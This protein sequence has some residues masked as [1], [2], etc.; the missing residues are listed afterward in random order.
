MSTKMKIPAILCITF[1]TVL[2]LSTCATPPTGPKYVFLF[3]G[4][5]MGSN[6]VHAAEMYA[7]VL[8]SNSISSIKTAF[9]KFPVTGLMTNHSDGNFIT[10]S[11]ASGT[12]IA[13]GRK[14]RNGKINIDSDNKIRFETIAHAAKEKGMKVGIISSV[15]LNHATPASFY[16]QARH[17]SL[18]YEI[19]LQMAES[20][21]D[22][23]GGGGLLR[24]KGRRMDQPDVLGILEE[25]GFRLVMNREELLALR[26]GDG[27][28]VAC[29]EIQ[30]DDSAMPYE[31]DRE[32]E[33]LPLAAYVQKAQELLDNDQGFFLMVEG[34]KIDWACHD[35]DAAT[36]IRDTLAFS[37]AVEEA[38][39]FYEKHPEETLILVTADH[40]T[41]AFSLCS[42]SA[43]SATSIA[44]L[45]YQKKSMEAF[46]D[47][48]RQSYWAEDGWKAGSLNDLL[49]FIEENFGLHTLTRSEREDL[50]REATEG[51][52]NAR[53]KIELGLLPA[54]MKALEEAFAANDRGDLVET[55]V[56]ILNN[57]A[58]L[59]WA[60]GS[61]SAALL[62]VFAI[63]NGKESFSGTYDNTDIA[64]KLAALLDVQLGEAPVVSD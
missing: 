9:S 31:I 42:K 44:L 41:G 16:A 5:G 22:F 49:P 46:T 14:T 54:E 61:H 32:P 28:I 3:I 59:S 12:A 58:G 60:S 23:F 1:L 47:A 50:S 11:A 25:K 37:R 64:N 4:D 40:E 7:G 55:V 17:R 26:P 63:G 34:G 29:N 57:K 36:A 35:N 38:L 52:L 39:R 30:A 18:Y 45:S 6:Q 8:Q 33:D 53:R 51:D 10:D 27:R 21:F 56:R 13:S 19:A 48:L 15:S 43:T 62:P 2:L 24:P 20:S